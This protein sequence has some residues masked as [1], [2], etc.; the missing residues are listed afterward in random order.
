MSGAK[1]P[2]WGSIWIPFGGFPPWTGITNYA[3]LIR[4]KSFARTTS[5]T[6]NWRKSRRFDRRTGFH[7]SSGDTSAPEQF[8]PGVRNPRSGGSVGD[9]P[10]TKKWFRS[11]PRRA[12]AI[13]EPVSESLR[14]VTNSNPRYSAPRLSGHHFCKYSG[15]LGPAKIGLYN[16]L[17]SLSE[18]IYCIVTFWDQKYWSLWPLW[19]P[20]PWRPPF[21]Q[22][23]FGH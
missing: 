9:A 18:I 1:W 19:S 13:P 3:P 8:W 12:L 22:P 5:P 15:F 2:G 4:R 6:P 10:K 16:R 11:S 21:L 7:P 17:V 20:Y 23:F 14:G